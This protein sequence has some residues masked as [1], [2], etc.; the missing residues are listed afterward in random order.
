MSCVAFV[1]WRIYGLGT[2]L[3]WQI[4]RHSSIGPWSM[5]LVFSTCYDSAHIDLLLVSV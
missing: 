3:G 4:R 1:P 5:A 2:R